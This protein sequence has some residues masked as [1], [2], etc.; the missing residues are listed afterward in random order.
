MELS[1]THNSAFKIC[2]GAGDE[3]NWGGTPCN[4]A[5]ARAVKRMFDIG[6]VG[7]I[8]DMNGNCQAP[9][10]ISIKRL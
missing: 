2:F 1:S 7:R 5:F 10:H 6:S 9:V 4:A 3:E 8:T